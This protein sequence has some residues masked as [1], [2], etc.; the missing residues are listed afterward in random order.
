MIDAFSTPSNKTKTL[1]LLAVCGL[2]TIASVIVGIDDNPPGVILAFLA[3]VAFVLAFTHPWRTVKKY[4]L[5]FL[6]AIAGFVLF[7]I[8]NIVTDSI[9][10]N[11]ATSTA[12]L[13]LLQTPAIDALSLIFTMVFSAV[14]IVGAIGSLVLFMRSRR[15]TR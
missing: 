15:Q 5:L 6:A 1:V 2:L 3:G 12:I 10:G 9:A 8:L 14:L 13:N 4:L 7:I 11:P